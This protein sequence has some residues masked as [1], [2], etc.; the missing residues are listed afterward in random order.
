MRRL[1]L[2]NQ[3]VARGCYEAGVKVATAYPGTPSTEITEFISQYSEI[4]CE[5]APNEKVALEVAIGAA[6]YGKR[7]ICSMK[8]VGLNVA[9]DPLF[10]V[11]YTGV[12][13]GLLIAVADDPGMHSSQNEQDTR[14]IAKAAKVPVLEPADSQE[15]VDFVKKGFEIS[16]KYD[17]PVILRLTTRVSHSQS[18]VEEDSRVEIDYGYKK[19]IQKYVMMPAM[20]RKRHEIVEKRLNDLKEFAEKTELNRIEEGE[21]N[22][23]FITAGIAYQYVKEAYPDAWVLKLGMVYPLPERLV[24]DFCSKFEKVYIVEELD[25]FLEENIKAMGIRNAVGKEIFKMT[26]E[27]SPT[28]IKSAIEKTQVEPPYKLNE[29]LAPRLPVLC[30]GCPHRGIFYVL[31][32]IKDI[33]IT[34][35]IGCYTLG[36]LSPFNAMDT[37][38]CMGASV[39]MAHGISKASDKKA[40]VVAVIGDSTFV[41]SG[42][43]GLIDAVYNKSDM[44]LLILDNSTTGMTGHQ[45]HPATGYTI[46]GE[47]TFKLDLVS[48]CKTIGCSVVEEINPYNINEN[49]KKISTLIDKPGVK[50]LIVKAPCRLHR[51]YKYVL[52]KRYIDKN[53]CKNCKLCLSLGC[54]AISLKE[55][56]TI[57]QNLCLACGMCESICRFGA[58]SSVKE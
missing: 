22:L 5:W 14:N 43:T 28:F 25:P 7:A 20:A 42:I 50:V 57:D 32:K 26:G 53:K 3:A 44:L 6:I 41:H 39:G 9:A 4:Y 36:A 58:I 56:P 40:K 21:S 54:P 37:C 34:G 47:E 55:V 23:A 13:G 19:D 1:M 46:R 8:H 52:S 2:G 30:P 45:D 49:I 33:I 29:E 24:K 48:L 15:C 18:V 11:S 17:T 27:Y 16:E 12:N 10:T 51:R 31:S 35:D 38:I